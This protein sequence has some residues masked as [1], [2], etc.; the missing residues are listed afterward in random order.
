[1]FGMSPSVWFCGRRST[2]GAAVLAAAIFVSLSWQRFT[3]GIVYCMRHF[4]TCTTRGM[5]APSGTP[6]SV[7]WPAASVTVYAIGIPES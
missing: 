3:F 2:L 5:F 1:M 6:V 4:P 7:K